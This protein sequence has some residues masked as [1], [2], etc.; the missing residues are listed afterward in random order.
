VGRT[1]EVQGLVGPRTTV[2]DLHGRCVLP[3]FVDA[4]AH[5]SM[6]VMGLFAVQLKD[7]WPVEECCRRVA[8]FAL[9]HPE[10][11]VVR[12]G[13]W[14]DA[15][16]PEHGPRKEDLD[17]VVHDRPVILSSLDYHSVWVNS[18]ALAA[19]GITADT[20]DPEGGTIERVPGTSEP[21]GTLRE[22]AAELFT[23]LAADYTPWQVEKGL[24][25]YQTKIAAPLGV[26]AVCDAARGAD[27]S[28]C[29]AYR[30]LAERGALK[31]W[32]RG[33]LKLRPSDDVEAW[34]HG[35]IAERERSRSPRFAT[36]AVKFFIDG[37]VEG[38][39]AYLLDDYANE[40]GYRGV[41][42]WEDQA[43][44]AAFA[45]VDAAGFQIHVHTIG[46]AAT[47]Q[48]LDAL[49]TAAA[50]AA[51]RAG[52]SRAS[53]P[54]IGSSNAARAG[55]GGPCAARADGSSAGHSG[56]SPFRHPPVL[57]HLQLVT[58]RDVG[59]MAEL[60]VIAVINPYWFEIGEPHRV[61]EIP[62]LGPERANHE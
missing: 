9:A 18:R 44:A 30:G 15:I 61:L 53:H 32:M 49:E 22:N 23:R 62:Y 59:R 46:D 8:Q 2:V 54:G 41:A 5:I 29:Q 24:E 17:R 35:A 6:A 1:A 55:A 33:A 37:V 21:S 20:P 39:T 48:T 3:G 26:T 10:F 7:T 60:G 34:L 28:P 25:H 50:A 56:S 52:G 11:D 4:H 51:A 57:T 45:A 19:A 43:L 13:G 40:P 58:P 14:S 47:Q 38:G 42:L 12:G 31:L 36:T 16:A 27:Q